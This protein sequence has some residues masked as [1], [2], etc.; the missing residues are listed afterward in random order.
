MLTTFL[1]N[2]GFFLINSEVEKYGATVLNGQGIANN[3][4]AVC[5]NLPAAFGSAVTT[6]VSMN[7][8]AKYADKA[9]KSC[10]TGMLL[11]AITA[12]Y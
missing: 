8:G 4:T 6:M 3:I 5:F 10:Y 2:L 7:I 9:K 11:S 12:F 1:S